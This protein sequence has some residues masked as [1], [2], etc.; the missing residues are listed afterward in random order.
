MLYENEEDD[1]EMAYDD[2]IT[3]NVV[4][5]YPN[6]VKYLMTLYD[7]KEEWA[8]CYRKH[9]LIRGNNTNNPVGAQFLVLKDDILNRT[10]EFNINGLLDKL[11]KEFSDHYKVKILNV[12]SGRFDGCYTR[13][14]R[15]L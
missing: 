3:S 10:K 13:L 6:L 14:L 7:R 2:M 4:S 1:G 9:L 12:A 11:T 5:K 8:L 15:L